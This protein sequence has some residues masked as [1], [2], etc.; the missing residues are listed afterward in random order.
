MMCLGLTHC[1][2]CLQPIPM[3]EYTCKQCAEQDKK[4]R[5]EKIDNIIDMFDNFNKYELEAFKE[6]IV[7]KGKEYKKKEIEKQI[8]RL[9][10]EMEEKNGR[11]RR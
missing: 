11:S 6:L 5:E 9:Q 10:K 4:T 1:E 2:R 7:E 8:K 3:D